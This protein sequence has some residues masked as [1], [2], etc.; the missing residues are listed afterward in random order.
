MLH[1]G[2][3]WHNSEELKDT[4]PWDGA[5]KVICPACKRVKDGVC[6]GVLHLDSPL[7][8]D[9]ADEVMQKLKS[10]EKVESRYNHLSRIV[11]VSR[12]GNRWDV[13]TTTSHLAVELGKRIKKAFGGELHVYPDRSGHA[14][15]KGQQERTVSVNWKL[16]V[17]EPVK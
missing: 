3:M 4:S 8:K 12:N 14:D 16:S 2:K 9:K 1:N 17:E 15:R 10:E 7:L 5:E 11:K 6:L 13:F